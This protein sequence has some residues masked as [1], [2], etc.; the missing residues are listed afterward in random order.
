MVMRGHRA[1]VLEISSISAILLLAFFL[2]PDVIAEKDAKTTEKFSIILSSKTGEEKNPNDIIKDKHPNISKKISQNI[3]KTMDIPAGPLNLNDPQFQIKV[4]AYIYLDKPESVSSL[5]TNLDIKTQVGKTVAAKLSVKEMNELSELDVVQRITQPHMAEFYGHAL[6]QGVAFTMADD[7]HS[8]GIDGSGV[9]VGI[10]DGGFFPN[11]PEISS[12]VVSSMLFD[13]FNF[14]NGDIA[15]G[16]SAGNSHGTAVA[17]IVVDEAPGASLLLATISTNV[18]YIN[19]VVYLKDN[20]ADIITASLGFPTLGSDGVD[21][22]AQYFRAGTS[23]VAKKMDD[24]FNNGIFGTISAGNNGDSH[25]MGTY[26]PSPTIPSWLSSRGWESVMVFQPNA[27]GL[28]KGCL[29]FTNGGWRIIAAWDDAITKNN[30]Y[31][32]FVFKSNMKGQ[33]LSGGTLFQ[34]PNTPIEVAPGNFRPGNQCI[35]IASFSS[36]EDHDF[37]IYTNN[38]MD[39][40]LLVRAGSLGTPADSAGVM[41]VGAINFATNNLEAFSSWGPTDDGRA[42]PEICGPDGT[43]SHQSGLNPFFGTSASAPHTAGAAALFLQQDPSLTPTQLKTIMENSARFNSNYSIVNRCGAN[44]GALEVTDIAPPIITLNGV[45]PTL[46]AGIDTYTELGAT[47]TDTVDGAFAAQV[48]G[49]AVD[50][51]TPGTY[52]VEY[53]A[54]DS[55]GNAAIPVTRD[56]TVVDTTPPETT[57]NSTTDGN[58]NSVSEGQTT[59]SPSIDIAF[60]GT[61]NVTLPSNL[62]FECNLDG[63]GYSACSSP[64]SLSNLD[65]GTHTLEIRATDEEGITESTA[66]FTWIVT[67]VVAH[68]LFDGDLIDSGP[69]SLDGTWN[70]GVS[71][72]GA[73]ISGRIGQGIELVD[74]TAQYANIADNSNLDFGT[75]SYSVMFWIA[76]D[77]DDQPTSPRIVNKRGASGEGWFVLEQN[78]KMKFFIQDDGTNS[79][80]QLFSNIIGLTVGGNLVFHHV[81][82]VVDRDDP[83]NQEVRAYIDGVKRPEI[84]NINSITGSVSNTASLTIGGFNNDPTKN[85]KGKLDEVQLIRRALSDAQVASLYT[86]TSQRVHYKFQNDLLDS[87]PNG[88]HALFAGGAA[89]DNFVSGKISKAFFAEGTEHV[90][91]SDNDELEIENSSDSFSITYW[92]KFINVDQP[93]KPRVVEKR[94]AGGKGW[95]IIEQ[96]GK[97]QFF[98]QDDSAN[99]KKGLFNQGIGNGNWHHVAIVVDGINKEVRGYTDGIQ[100]NLGNVDGNG[101]SIDISSLTGTIAN[102]FDVTIGG[103]GDPNKNFLGTLDELQFFKRTLSDDEIRQAAKLSPQAFTGY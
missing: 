83:L 77:R 79:A 51:S 68:Y 14:C 6:S 89:A 8:V 94:G 67:S 81:V 31:D 48:G 13:A 49:D 97:M 30:D 18:D 42:K 93:A 21:P 75:G 66:T 59:S 74:T 69:N 103:N 62:S 45:T 29:P 10:I 100:R 95:F 63:T 55:A 38:A 23:D 50:D 85:V 73:F 65:D 96:N 72:V 19:A 1:K 9:T 84:L 76:F 11:N 92:T 64:H 46:E 86:D 33:P 32:L 47:A 28:Q 101:P 40:S 34:P 53:T 7:F 58:S 41:A 61:D 56:V 44:S 35:V 43:L 88:I 98:I 57:I 70:G 82:M 99:K 60:S 25:F 5:P 87:G 78:G 71:N 102:N 2:V 3:L 39:P 54:T 37:H 27:N 52:T 91:T 20:G 26:V 90:T 15:C 36:S 12:N 80:S 16:A 17:E 4:P 22:N 24:A